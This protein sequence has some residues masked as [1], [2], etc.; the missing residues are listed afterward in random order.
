MDDLEQF[1]PEFYISLSRTGL[2]EACVGDFT[3]SNITGQAVPRLS[4]LRN[5]W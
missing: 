5:E 1:G 3:T 2:L 4:K